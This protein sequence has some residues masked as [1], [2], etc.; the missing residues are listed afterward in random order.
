MRLCMYGIARSLARQKGGCSVCNRG[1]SWD[2]ENL[3]AVDDDLEAGAL[4]YS[5]RRAWPF[6]DDRS[7]EHRPAAAG[8]SEPAPHTRASGMRRSVTSDDAL[9]RPVISESRGLSAAWR[10][11]SAAN[12][13]VTALLAQSPAYRPAHRLTPL[14]RDL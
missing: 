8:L 1:W 5:A 10:P 3:S 13:Q 6:E 7:D 11:I 2:E 12:S 4:V 14:T 9:R